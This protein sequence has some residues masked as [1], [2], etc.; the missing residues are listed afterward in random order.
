[1]KVKPYKN[2]FYSTIEERE[3]KATIVTVYFGILFLQDDTSTVVT[4]L[5]LVSIL[6]I[7]LWFLLG[8]AY[9]FYSICVPRKFRSTKILLILKYISL[10]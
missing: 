8:W 2:P 3:M 7:N 9:V 1:M 6:G 10:V 5:G 4:V